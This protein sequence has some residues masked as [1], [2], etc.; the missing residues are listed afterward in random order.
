MLASANTMCKHPSSTVTYLLDLKGEVHNF[1]EKF[2]AKYYIAYTNKIQYLKAI[3]KL[4]PHR[5]TV[6]NYVLFQHFYASVT[7]SFED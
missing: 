3:N 1:S 7:D 6:I 5:Y 2:T 4:F